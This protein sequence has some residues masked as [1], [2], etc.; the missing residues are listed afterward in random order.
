VIVSLNLTKEQQRRLEPLVS[1]Q[2]PGQRAGIFF[3]VGSVWDHE[4]QAV[5]LKAH[6]ASLQWR[7]AQ[8]VCKLIL[9]LSKPRKENALE[10]N[11]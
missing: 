8:K 10:V 9:K 4:E 1:Q 7:D 5:V 3:V 2:R 6:F 11:N